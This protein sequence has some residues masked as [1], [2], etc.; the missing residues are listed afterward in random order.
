[1]QNLKVEFENDEGQ[2]LAGILDL[3]ATNVRA[4]ALFAHCFTCSKNLKAATNISRAMTAAGIGVLRFDFTGLGQSEGDFAATNF[5]SNVRDLL[6]AAAFL[7]ANYAAPAILL[8]HS[9]GGTAVLQAAAS[10]SSAVAVATIG[11]PS[12]PA[13]VA[14]MFGD[15]RDELDEKGYAEV[16][17]GGRP[18]TVRQQFLDDLRQHNLPVAI[19]SLRKALLIMHAPL[20]AVV[21]IDNAGALF[22]AAKHPKS[23]VS[24]DKADHLLSSNEDSLYAG[25]VLAAWASR[26]LPTLVPPTEL[27]AGSGEVIART[28]T[29]GF[30]TDVRAGKHALLADEPVAV[31][32]TDLGPTPYDLLSAALATCTTMTLK[33]YASHK[34]LNLRSTTVRVSHGKVH[35]EDCVDCESKEGRIDQFRRSISFDGDLTPQQEE[36]LLEIA[37]RCPVHRTLHGEIKVRSTLG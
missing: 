35:A 8:G 13:H 15:A 26:Y 37:D 7:A 19:G 5:S 11:S 1:M 14:H 6:A 27:A 34:K 12:E 21:E 17:L 22:A 18:F 4:Y 20:D 28:F 29:D 30:R 3:P 10:L 36:R 2:K 32:G 33:M 23:F 16:T 24:L 9:L 31:G 25:R